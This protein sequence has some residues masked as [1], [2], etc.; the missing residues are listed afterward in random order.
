MLQQR[1][2]CINYRSNI[3]EESQKLRRSDDFDMVMVRLWYKLGELEKR[4]QRQY[5]TSD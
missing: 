5:L 1:I 2:F 4:M 3:A